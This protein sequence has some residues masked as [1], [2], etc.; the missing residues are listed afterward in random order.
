[1]ENKDFQKIPKEEFIS[2]YAHGF[3]EGII[4]ERKRFKEKLDQAI[5]DSVVRGG[6]VNGDCYLSLDLLTKYINQ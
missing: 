1:M 6:M 2:D 5:T 3:Q 4:C